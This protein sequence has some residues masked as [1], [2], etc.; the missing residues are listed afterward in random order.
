MDVE[1]SLNP[2]SVNLSLM[3][4]LRGL[5]A[6]I[7]AYIAL[8]CLS[9]SMICKILGVVKHRCSREIGIDEADIAWAAVRQHS[10]F[11][12]GRVACLELSLAFVLFALTKGLSTTFCVGVATEPFQA[13][14]WVNLG[15]KPFREGD[16]LEHHFRRLFTI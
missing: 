11:F 9:L 4:R 8:R 15:G 2:I 16:H 12:L 1:M 6:V 10:F 14:A 5:F 13:H 7:I 3:A